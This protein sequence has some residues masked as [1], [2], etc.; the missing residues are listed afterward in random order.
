MISRRF[1][2]LTGL[3]AFAAS[4][5]FL[6]HNRKYW[7]DQIHPELL[8]LVNE[9]HIG[10]SIFFV[11]SGFLLAYSYGAKPAKSLSAYRDYIIIRIA[12]IFPLYWLILTAYYVDLRF[13][14]MD[15]SILTYT[16]LHGFSSTLNLKGIAQAWSLS[17]EFSFYLLMPLLCIL[18][19]KKFWYLIFFLIGLFFLSYSIGLIWN[20]INGNPLRF[21][22]PLKF[23]LGSTFAGR[24]TEFLAGMILAKLVHYENYDESLFWRLKNKTWIGFIGMFAITY[25]I[26]CFQ[27]DIF[28]HGADHPFGYL[29]LMFI[30]PVFIV[31]TLAGLITE[32]TYLQQF[33]ASKIMILLGNASFAFYLIH[34]SYVNIRLRWIWL[35]P[36]RNFVLLWVIAILLYVSFEKPVYSAIKKLI[37][38][39]RN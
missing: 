31:F 2:A 16:L 21:L 29:I 34:I 22:S 35:G 25:L 5:V 38:G 17:V 4:L 27:P 12:R 3:R 10:V 32:C 6:Y 7:R 18:E 9:F 19:R 26:G 1:D 15:F 30:L 8:R 23:I 14:K 39:Q 13:G 24:F 20:E 37:K 36:D 28:H 11:L 33:F